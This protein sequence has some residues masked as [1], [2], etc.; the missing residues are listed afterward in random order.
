MVVVVIALSTL[1]DKLLTFVEELLWLIDLS[2]ANVVVVKVIFF[3]G[4]SVANAQTLSASAEP[5]EISVSFSLHLLQ[6]E[7][8]KAFSVTENIVC[9]QVLHLRLVVAVPLT[10]TIWP[11]TQVFH[12]VQMNPLL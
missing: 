12:C 1:T 7:H 6:L 10:A 9:G 4:R 2:G 3:S 11:G 8:K 5:E